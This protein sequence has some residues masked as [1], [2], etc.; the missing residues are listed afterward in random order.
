MASIIK[1][2]ESGEWHLVQK[3]IKDWMRIQDIPVPVKPEAIRKLSCGDDI[4]AS[5]LH[6]FG[7]HFVNASISKK[8]KTQTGM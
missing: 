8:E 3:W 5:V 2:F 6:S 1:K 7:N 4:M